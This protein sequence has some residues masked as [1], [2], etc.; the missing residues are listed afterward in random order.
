[1]KEVLDRIF[2]GVVMMGWLV[3]MRLKVWDIVDG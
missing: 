1:M 2:V 3:G